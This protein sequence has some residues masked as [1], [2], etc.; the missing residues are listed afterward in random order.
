[1]FI[2]IYDWDRPIHDF[3]LHSFLS[4]L[5]F[6]LSVSSHSI[7][8]NGRGYTLRENIVFY[9]LCFHQ[10]LALILVRINF[11]VRVLKTNEWSRWMSNSNNILFV[12]GFGFFFFSLIFCVL[13]P[14]NTASLNTECS[15]R[16]PN[17]HTYH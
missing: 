10:N 7:L 15:K 13:E 3:F 1:M 2:F 11:V 9:F 14:F 4:H 16:T 8:C 6:F 12:S 17:I 5:F